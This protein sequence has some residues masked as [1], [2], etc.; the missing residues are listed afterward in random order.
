[1]KCGRGIFRD[2][3]LSK[4]LRDMDFGSLILSFI[5]RPVHEKLKIIFLCD[6]GIFIIT[7]PLYYFIHCR[8][9]IFDSNG[10]CK[11]NQVFFLF[12]FVTR[13]LFEKYSLQIGKM[14]YKILIY[15][16]IYDYKLYCWKYICKDFD[17]DKFYL[18]LKQ[19]INNV[20]QDSNN[21]KLHRQKSQ[22]TLNH[23]ITPQIHQTQQNPNFRLNQ[24]QPFPNQT[25]SPVLIKR[26]ERDIKIPDTYPQNQRRKS[27]RS[28]SFSS[29]N[30]TPHH[31]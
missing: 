18:V 9:Y 24:L 20:R 4:F 11:K 23:R 1:M 19:V 17:F 16:I 30:Q 3:N 27:Q 22:S 15:D 5:A 10:W 26:S 25:L 6:R 7:F 29:I 28:T 8:R 12:F 21:C 14:N 13:T 31:H 2:W